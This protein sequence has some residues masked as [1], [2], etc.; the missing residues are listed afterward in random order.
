MD[1]AYQPLHFNRAY[2][3]GQAAT[4]PA[5]SHANHG[6]KFYRFFLSVPRLSGQCDVLPVL[7]PQTLLWETPLHPGDRVLLSGQLRSFNNR[8]PDG[9]RLILSLFAREM[10]RTDREP[11]N[12]I[13]LSGTICKPPHLRRT[14]LGR[15]ICDVILAVNR[16]YGRADYLPCITWGAVAQRTAGLTVG[17]PLALEGRI[18]SRTYNKNVGGQMQQRT[19]YEVSVMHPAT[20]EELLHSDFP[21]QNVDECPASGV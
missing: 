3:C 10:E 11:I 15:E 12:R 1:N 4:E 16:H 21:H 17:S 20:A 2:I 13:Q 8:S 6:E 9:P 18:Q 19:A 7:V 5:L 14:P